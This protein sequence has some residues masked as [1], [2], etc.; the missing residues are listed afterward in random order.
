MS[1]LRMLQR[2]HFLFIPPGPESSAIMI[3]DLPNQPRNELPAGASPPELPA[4]PSRPGTENN[5]D[6]S[7]A[8]QVRNELP[9]GTSPS[10]LPAVPSRPGTERNHDKSF[11]EQVRNELSAGTCRQCKN[12]GLFSRGFC[13]KKRG[14][15]KMKKRKESNLYNRPFRY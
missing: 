13:N 4:V 10:E 2:F 1:T 8:E 3:S 15:E 11:A 6:T 9:A 14:E 7:F 12:R 5:Q